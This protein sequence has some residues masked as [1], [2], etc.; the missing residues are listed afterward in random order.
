MIYRF[1]A[2]VVV[3]IHLF[4]IIFAV[5]GGLAALRW[6]KIAWF[7]IPAATWAILIEFFG[8]GCPSTPLEKFLIEK[9]GEQGYTGGFVEHYIIPIIYPLEL[10]QTMQ[11]IIGALILILNGAIYWFW[12]K[13][14]TLFKHKT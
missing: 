2:D 12:L 3:L 4:F 13:K 7:H 14:F 10:T 8:W 11:F 6:R 9:G 1:L 5:L